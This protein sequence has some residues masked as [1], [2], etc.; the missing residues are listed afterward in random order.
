[1]DALT[2]APETP[3]GESLGVDATALLGRS[4]FDREL[5]ELPDH[6]LVEV[7]VA[8]RRLASRVQAV[9]LA[10]VAE[11]ARRRFAAGEASA[12][13]VIS[14]R[15]YLND[16]VAA[17][18][19]LT[20]SSADGLIRFATE[21]VGRLPGTFAALAAGDVDYLKA[22]TL[23]QGTGQV[24]DEVAAA[25][26]AKVLPRAQGQ[27]SGEIRAKVRRL[28]KRLDPQALG[29][30]REEAERRRGVTLMETDDGTAHLTGV[31]LPAEAAGAAYGRV[32]AIAAGLK[33]DGDG[34]QIDQLRA[35]VFVALLRGTL[36]T[37][38]P[39]ADTSGRLVT[40]PVASPDSGWT[41]GDD[42]VADVIAGTARAGLTALAADQPDRREF[43]V[44]IAQAGACMT[45]SLAALRVRWCWSDHDSPHPG[46]LGPSSL[47]PNGLGPSGPGSSGLG[48]NA[49]GHG[50]SGHA[51]PGY[52]VPAAMRRLIEHRDRRCCF[53]GCRRP[54]RHCD[55][56]HSI[57][58]HRGGATCPCNIAMLCR[59]HH[60]LKQTPGWRLEH[61]WPGVILWIGPTG[62]WKITAPADRE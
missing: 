54:V 49:L 39:P 32:A 37:A 10:A 59:R 7:M 34:R 33:R 14:P 5:P 29:R 62:H 24:S 42:T 44:L 56:D 61:L 48:P 58:F 22:R 21:L 51:G 31:D 43:G 26:E 28:V 2:Q 25:I 57:P 16:E 60:R 17:A 9:E 41:G 23:W 45:E 35:D 50:D 13:E 40:G 4:R 52:R 30:R 36:K 55:A 15:D 6:E 46:V 47:G 19:T 1:V 53:P 3:L 8:A 12:V 11:L 18:L 38:Q 20:P 27:T